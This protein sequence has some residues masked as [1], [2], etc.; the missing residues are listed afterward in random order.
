M[1][2]KIIITKN[3]Q[4]N[5][6]EIVNYIKLDSKSRAQSWLK[7]VK[8]KIKSLKSNPR[9]GRKVPEYEGEKE[10]REIILGS[11]RIIYEID[12]SQVYVLY[13]YHGA[14]LLKF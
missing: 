5:L 11:Y 6:E 7:I 3:A 14:R 4:D 10:I 2:Y 12:D 1:N 9:R 8:E 13:V